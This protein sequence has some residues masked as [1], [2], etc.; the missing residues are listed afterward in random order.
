[1]Q[2]AGDLARKRRDLLQRYGLALALAGLALFLRGVLPF[3]EGTAIYQLP[4]AAVVLSAWYGGRGPG[5]LASLICI[6]GA[7]YWFVP[8]VKSFATSADHALPF[9][10]FVGLCVLLTEFSAGRRRSERALRASE[11][12]F[13]TLVQFSFDVYW[14]S[15]AEHRFTRQEFSE[16]LT[17]APAPGAEIGKR[18]WE[19]PYLEPD[20]EGWRRHRATLDA[21]LPFQDFELARAAPDGGKRYVSV[22]GMPVFDEAGRFA[23]Y[24][25][26]G[27]HI[28]ERRRAAEALREKDN[29][30]RTARTELARVS[31][32]TTLGELTAS[33]VH[34]VSQ[35]LSAMVARAAAGAR[36]LAAEPPDIAETRSAL[37]HIAADGKR[38]REVIARVRALTKRQAPRMELLDVNRKVREVLALAEHELKTH[39]IVLRTELAPALPGVAGDRVQLQQVLLNLIV[40]AIEAMSGVHDR[41][42]ELTIATAASEPHAVVVEVRDSG[43]GLNEE[44]AK[45]VFEPF[46]TT[47]EQGIGIGLSI[48]RSIVEAHRGRLWATSNQPHGAVFRFSLPVAQQGA[49]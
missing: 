16:R 13:R 8:P 2:H 24:R 39:D 25:G 27:R 3:R 18:R 21:H 29:A 6:T 9:S 26:V 40:N 46:Y 49:A 7:S 44:G 31:R 12:R 47:K 41:P 34:E 23:G 22:S 37:D 17:D 14:E 36:W 32:L 20:E 48:S 10:I 11:E 43:P 28:T 15:D 33:I 45:Q 1:V 38:A 4:L 42:R 19:I 5:L 30:L 35:P